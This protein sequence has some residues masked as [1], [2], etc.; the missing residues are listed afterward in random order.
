MPCPHLQSSTYTS[1]FLVV[2]VQPLAQPSESNGLE[3]SIKFCYELQQ[4]LKLS[5]SNL[6]PWKTPVDTKYFL[7]TFWFSTQKTWLD[8][9]AAT[10]KWKAAVWPPWSM[11]VWP[12]RYCVVGMWWCLLKSHNSKEQGKAELRTQCFS[13]AI[14]SAHKRKSCMQQENALKAFFRYL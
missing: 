1:A 5:L 13:W 14:W 12:W 9:R 10:T 2:Q 11:N 8:V 4:G 3:K 6:K 7:F